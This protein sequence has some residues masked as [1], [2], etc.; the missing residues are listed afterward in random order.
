M[1]L[2]RRGKG[3]IFLLSFDPWLCS[4][5]HVFAGRRCGQTCLLSGFLWLHTKV[6]ILFQGSRRECGQAHSW[7]QR[8]AL[9]CVG[10]S[11]FSPRSPGLTKSS[12]RNGASDCYFQGRNISFTN[13]SQGFFFKKKEYWLF[14]QEKTKTKTKGQSTFLSSYVSQ[15]GIV[16]PS[17]PTG[18]ELWPDM[19]KKS[20]KQPALKQTAGVALKFPTIPRNHTFVTSQ[21]SLGKVLCVCVF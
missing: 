20:Q 17:A 6:L 18:D 4:H 2:S 11:L 12:E 16:L 14:R 21:W 13:K 1:H 15:L 9:V 7:D 5:R 3:R 8:L 10:R 19:W